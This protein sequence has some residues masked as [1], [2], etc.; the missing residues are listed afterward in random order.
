MHAQ[1]CDIRIARP[2]GGKTRRNAVQH[3]THSIS[4]DQAREIGGGNT[5][6]L[7]GRWM[8]SPSRSRT[9]NASRSGVA[10]A[11]FRRNMLL[12]QDCAR[13]IIARINPLPKRLGNFIQQTGL[14]APLVSRQ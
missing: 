12:P 4:I 5:N 13:C 11:K 6:P 7:P 2:F 14:T 8:T 10:D 9:R 1:L 3:L